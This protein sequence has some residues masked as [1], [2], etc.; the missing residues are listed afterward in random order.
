M[1]IDNYRMISIVSVFS[2]V[3]EMCV[4]D[5]LLEHL[6]I[7]NGLSEYQFGFRP[8]LSTTKALDNIVSEILYSFE[9]FEY[10]D[11]TL[12]DLSKAFDSVSHNVLLDKLD[13]YGV[14]NSQLNFFKS[15]LCDRLNMVVI[16]NEHSSF[17]KV[18]AGVPQGSVLGPLLFL[19]CIND[20]PI[21][22]PA[23]SVLYADDTSFMVKSRNCLDLAAK[24][25]RALA[26]TK[27]WCDSNFLQ[28]NENKTER[29]VFM[30]RQC[31]IYNYD[32][33]IKRS[34]E[35][36]G[37]TLDQKLTW[38]EHTNKVVTKLSR[39]CFLLRKLKSCVNSD[40]MVMAYFSFFHNHLLYANMLWGNSRGAGSVF[41]WQKKAIRILEGLSFQDSCRPYFNK[42]NI[43]TLSGIF[44]YQNLVYVKENLKEFAYH[45]DMHQYQ[46]RNSNNILL[47]NVRLAKFIKSHKYLQVK[48]FNK[49]PN[50]IRLL[51]LS[52]FKT[53]ISKWL[54][55][56]AFY[57]V[58]EF[59]SCDVDSLKFT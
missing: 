15:Y 48:F 51:D 33:D 42:Y 7:F 19:L 58:E 13:F 38:E 6:A 10:L 12:V 1:F 24:R 2:K 28:I 54:I 46:T 44:I 20:L 4:K 5:Q 18:L 49:L 26:S 23:K 40:L 31:E 32:R 53:K 14:H 52:Y 56:K 45:R 34:V 22:V 29:I 30:L 50:E 37:I 21:N 16:G 36:L 55:S 41:I 59:L 47:P 25:N 8:G 35:L 9:A 11:M 17:Q 3:L 43:M 39:V 27:L 57:S